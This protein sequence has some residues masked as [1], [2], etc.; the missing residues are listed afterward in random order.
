MNGLF[1]DTSAL[2]RHYNRDRG[3]EWIVATMVSGAAIYISAL[4]L[5][6]LA[7]A[8]ARRGKANARTQRQARRMLDRLDK[9]TASFRVLAIGQDVLDKAMALARSGSVRGA[10]AVQL[11]TALRLSEIIPQA[12]GSPPV[13]VCADRELN[14][15]AETH[16]LSVENPDDHD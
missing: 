11:A 3:A 1:M 10:D 15:A 6:E 12:G 4:T 16:G 14:A 9:D 7:A 8:I 5:I 2:S 13:F